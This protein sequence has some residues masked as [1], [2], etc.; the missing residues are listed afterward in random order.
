[1]DLNV[2]VK[3]VVCFQNSCQALLERQVRDGDILIATS[4]PTAYTASELPPS[5]GEE[6]YFMQHY[7]IWPVWND[8][9]CWKEVESLNGSPSIAMAD[10]TPDDPHLAQYKDLVD[11]SYSLPVRII[12]TSEWEEKI[13]DQLGENSVGSVSYGVDHEL[14]YPSTTTEQQTVLALYRNSPEKGDRQAIAA[15]EKLH[16]RN[17]DIEFLMFG[18]S[19]SSQVPRF[20]EFEED[21]SQ[22]MIRDLYSRSDIFVYPSWVEG[23]GMPP[24]EAMACRNALVSTDVG[25]VRDYTPQEGVEFVPVRDVNAIVSKVE[26]L[27]Q[28][29]DRLESMKERNREYIQQFRWEKTAEEFESII[30][31]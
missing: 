30:T 17:E 12:R 9:D 7:E 21:P 8:L 18:R 5:K 10:V 4:W 26:R 20:V 24:M 28:S 23:Y 15:F 11:E 25:A 31:S 27:L 19:K 3:K 29:P 13:L 6:Y 14:F 16:R 2:P 1:M 22:E